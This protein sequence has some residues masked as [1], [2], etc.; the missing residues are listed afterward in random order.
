MH[1]V[2]Y[3]LISG[4]VSRALRVHLCPAIVNICLI[5]RYRIARNTLIRP[6]CARCS[7]VVQTGQFRFAVFVNSGKTGRFRLFVVFYFDVV[8]FVAFVYRLY[9]RHLLLSS[10]FC[11]YQSYV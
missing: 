10:T 4:A 6:I 7:E 3:L 5:L 9:F 8:N 11:Q 1:P 2:V